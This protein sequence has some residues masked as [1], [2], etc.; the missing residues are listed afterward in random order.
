MKPEKKPD[1][2]VLGSEINSLMLYMHNRVAE[3]IV[4]LLQ[5]EILNFTELPLDLTPEQAYTRAL[6]HARDIAKA[7]IKDSVTLK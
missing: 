1:P 6:Q 2:R 5:A 7:Q 3:N 4:S